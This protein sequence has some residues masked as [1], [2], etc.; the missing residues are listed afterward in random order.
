MNPEPPAN[1]GKT[2]ITMKSM[3]DMK[4]VVPGDGPAKHRST[5]D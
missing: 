1:F 3:K 5:R 4:G 2:G